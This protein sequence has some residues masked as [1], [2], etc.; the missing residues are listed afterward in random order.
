MYNIQFFFYI[1]LFNFDIHFSQVTYITFQFS[2]HIISLPFCSVEFYSG[3]TALAWKMP[4]RLHDLGIPFPNWHVL[5]IRNQLGLTWCTV[6]CW[7]IQ[8]LPYAG[9]LSSLDIGSHNK[10]SFIIVCYIIYSLL[11][12]WSS[13]IVNRPV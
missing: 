8:C 4:E 1:C 5:L 12:T 11:W 13:P 9:C 7:E 6:T 2:S 3:C 10:F